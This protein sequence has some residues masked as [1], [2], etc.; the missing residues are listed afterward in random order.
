VSSAAATPAASVPRCQR[1]AALRP[2]AVAT[3]CLLADGATLLVSHHLAGLLQ[4]GD[5]V[6]FLPCSTGSV[7]TEL[8]VVRSGR[9][10]PKELYLAAIGYVT[11]PKQ[12]KRLESYLRAEVTGSALGIRSI[13]LATSAVRDYFYRADR[14]RDW[15]DSPTLYEALRVDRT[16]SPGDVRLA[17]K[18]RRLELGTGQASRPAL[19]D[20]DRAFNLLMQPDIR[21]CYDALLSDPEAPALFPYSGFGALLTA[22]ELSR[23]RATFFAQRILSFLPNRRQRHFRAPL[24]R[25]EFLH[26]HVAYLDSRRKVEVL[27]DPI[28]LPL[29]PD[30]TWNQWSHLLGAKI[31]IEATF[32]T[33]GK[34][35]LRSG[36]WQL[37]SWSTA[38]SSSLRVTLPADIQ[39]QVQAARTAH[40]RFGQYSTAL[41]RIRARL[42]REPL[43]R[44]ELDRLCNELGVPGDFDVAQISWKPDYDSFFY[45][46]LRNRAARMY[47]HRDEYIFDLDRAIV[48]EVPEIGHATYVFA[49]PNEIDHFV[50]VYAT[51]TKDDIRKNRDGIAERLRFLGRVMHGANPRTWLREIKERIGEP[52]GHTD[53]T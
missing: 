49:K 31:G 25:I 48:V 41:E 12:D 21:S 36:G 7:A 2:D 34:C 46:Q 22:G 45:N 17:Y 9:G 39:D 27:L 33:S 47:L 42:E 32:V 14:T 53:V 26:D 51:T 38:L 3:A 5:A 43:E 20:L 19:R 11:Q 24:R 50:R 15:P 13:H 23:D 6:E 16:A 1:I 18:V 30:P 28:V 29:A 35:R 10:R 8:R 40:H 4:P 44:R 37:T 52:V